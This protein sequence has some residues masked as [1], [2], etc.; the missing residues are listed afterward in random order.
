MA[1]IGEIV[2][3]IVRGG[4]AGA[5]DLKETIAF[6]TQQAKARGERFDIRSWLTETYGKIRQRLEEKNEAGGIEGMTRSAEQMDKAALD[7]L[8]NAVKFS[9]T[10]EGRALMAK[11]GIDGA[12]SFLIEKGYADVPGLGV[13]EEAGVVET[14]AP[15]AAPSRAGE[16]NW[17]NKFYRNLVPAKR[18]PGESLPAA[19]GLGKST[20]WEGE[21]F[22]STVAEDGSIVYD[23]P[24]VPGT[25]GYEGSI[26]ETLTEARPEPG[27][28]GA[29]TSRSLALGA[30][31]PGIAKGTPSDLKGRGSRGGL[32]V[33]RPDEVT[34]DW[35]SEGPNAAN[36][37]AP[38]EGTETEIERLL[39]GGARTLEFVPGRDSTATETLEFVPGR[40]KPELVPV[41]DPSTR[42]FL[43]PGDPGWAEGVRAEGT[44]AA[45][46]G[47]GDSLGD[48]A[49]MAGGD[50]G[51][52]TGMALDEAL[53][54]P[55][56]AGLL[57][58][59][60]QGE[61]APPSEGMSGMSLASGIVGGVG[62]ASAIANTITDFRTTADL[63]KMLAQSAAGDTV[64]RQEGRVAGGQ[65]QRNIMGSS[66]GRRDISPALALR[67]AQQAVAPALS[68]TYAQAAIESAR[69]R[70][71]SET[72]LAQL[73]KQRYDSLF[74]SLMQTA[75][76]V[77]SML[78][79][80]GAN[81]ETEAMAK[82]VE[83]LERRGLQDVT[84]GRRRG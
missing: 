83:A 2:N 28:L 31:V 4:G 36:K 71:Q 5:E 3:F 82:R 48:L 80:Q 66:M 64:A 61:G 23:I 47:L 30:R 84:G 59:G 57:G 32:M 38:F 27:E 13:L 81:K 19:P 46:G 63:E 43:V 11:Q 70:R 41:G 24:R 53:G 77:G 9:A 79:T 51:G 6:G 44:P 58:T 39:R 52:D 72:Q 35:A 40:D 26:S 62:I 68:D 55:P 8:S 69:E 18:S 14:T 17:G 10:D 33:D 7:Y 21:G 34:V 56:D 67:N 45:T 74:G 49:T 73:R 76:T 22:R 29:P 20:P 25:V 78:A 54:N 42:S 65:L 1:E 15:P 50:E 75:G 12:T 37:A 60:T 16:T